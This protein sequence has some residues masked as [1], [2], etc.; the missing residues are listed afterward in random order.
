VTEGRRPADH[1]SGVS[2]VYASF[3]P[4]YP[5]ELF[6]FVASIAPG[7]TFAWDAGAGTGQASVPL[8]ERFTHVIA[9]DISSEQIARARHHI[10]IEWHVTAAEDVPMIADASIDLVTVAQ[11]LH[12]FDHDRFYAEVRRVA[13]P[14]GAIAA[15]TYASPRMEGEAGALLHRYMYEDVGAYWPPERRYVQNEYRDISFPFE[16]IAAPPMKLEDE[17]TVEHVAGYLRSMSATARYVKQHGTDPVTRLEP[18]LRAAWG[19]SPARRITWPLIVL[20]GRV[21]HPA[22]S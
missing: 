10:L 20:A 1:F 22:S 9:T 5:A 13:V 17:W 7:R 3:R 21:Q 18:E 4:R 15:W 2:R 19:P 11:A 14:N 16:R 12:W 6:D 8:K